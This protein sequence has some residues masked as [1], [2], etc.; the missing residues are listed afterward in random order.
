MRYFIIGLGLGATAI[1]AVALIS[2]AIEEN[3]LDNKPITD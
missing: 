1:L 2:D 3:K